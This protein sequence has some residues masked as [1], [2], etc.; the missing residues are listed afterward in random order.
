MATHTESPKTFGTEIKRLLACI[1]KEDPSGARETMRQHLGHVTEVR[2][3]A[4]EA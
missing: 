3:R 4:E 2:H 1:K